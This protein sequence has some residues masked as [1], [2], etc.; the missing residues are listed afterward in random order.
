MCLPNLICVHMTD[1]S[2][3]HGIHLSKKGLFLLAYSSFLTE[4]KLNQCCVSG[5]VQCIS[6]TKESDIGFTTKQSGKKG[7]I[8]FTSK[9]FSFMDE[10][11]FNN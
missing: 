10:R 4:E 6:K 8:C 1:I 7:R 2:A 3:G 11:S 5:K 9:R